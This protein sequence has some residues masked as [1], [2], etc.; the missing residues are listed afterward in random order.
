M[1][2]LNNMFGAE[3]SHVLLDTEVSFLEQVLSFIPCV[4]LEIF[5]HIEANTNICSSFSHLAD[6]CIR[7]MAS[8]FFF[9]TAY[10]T[11]CIFHNL[12]SNPLLL[13]IQLFQCLF[14]LCYHKQHGE[15]RPCAHT[16]LPVS[17]PGM[18]L[19]GQGTFVCH[20][21]NCHQTSQPN[22]CYKTCKNGWKTLNTIVQSVTGGVMPSV[23][24]LFFS[25]L[26]HM[27]CC[28]ELRAMS[29][30]APSTFTAPTPTS[31]RCFP[32]PSSR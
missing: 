25:Y 6:F 26:P 20:F 11:T 13:D 31:H 19:L 1:F 24:G 16:F 5:I 29:P 17:V 9:T 28:L 15:D 4:Y 14:P 10:S 22:P 12:L 2:S 27:D 3:H 30:T 23:H 32:Q 21:Y 7:R 18:G 8:S